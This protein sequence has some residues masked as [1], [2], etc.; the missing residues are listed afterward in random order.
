MSTKQVKQLKVKTGKAVKPAEVKTT[1]AKPVEVAQPA[2]V[3]A[4]TTPAADPA[5]SVVEK[6]KSRPGPGEPLI[7]TA[8]VRRFLGAENL[9]R[10]V[11]EVLNP[12][13]DRLTAYNQAKEAL[14]K[15]DGTLSAEDK[16]K[17]EAVVASMDEATLKRLTLTSESL[18]EVKIRIAKDA[19]NV[20]RCVLENLLLSICDFAVANADGGKK[21][22]RENV[23]SE[24]L[25]E[26]DFYRLIHNLECV[27]KL[28]SEGR[29]QA[30]DVACEAAVKQAVK[31]LKSTFTLKEKKKKAAEAPAAA[32]PAAAPAV[33][34]PADEVLPEAPADP[35]S[36]SMFHYIQFVCGA[37]RDKHKGYRFTDPFKQLLC[38]IAEEF[39]AR[40]SIMINK[41]IEYNGVK[42]V[43]AKIIENV[44]AMMLTDGSTKHD[45]VKVGTEVMSVADTK[46]GKT[47]EYFK[48]AKETTYNG[49][50]MKYLEQ[51]ADKPS[52]TAVAP[53]AST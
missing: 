12:V 35:A 43:T 50:N 2:P 29:K 15:T 42:T 46:T 21:I 34:E 19:S 30:I 6:K 3:V 1:E 45:V 9:N 25:Y 26:A 41:Q 23:Y 48:V 49:C 31:N 10:A 7:A 47:T 11:L 24:A 33:A 16:A 37:A 39:I 27:R 17:F 53:A 36:T 14:A 13:R 51:R 8:R 18:D 28:T 40:V 38:S 22:E 52:Q 4:E 5:Q 20:L 32:E 44:V